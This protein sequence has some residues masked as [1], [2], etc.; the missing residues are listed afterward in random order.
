MIRKIASLIP[1]FLFLAAF[2]AP[3]PVASA[4]SADVKISLVASPD[5]RGAKGAAKYRNRG[6]EQEFQVEAE[7]SRRLAGAVFTV[8]VNDVAVGQMTINAF[9]KGRLSLNS[10]LG[11]AVP[12]ITPGTLVGV[13]T[14]DKAIVL[15][16][17][18]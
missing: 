13:T 18:F 11:D 6:G 4:N 17:K 1:L 2:V 16:G 12:V 5:F 8:W 14:A 3:T 9:G 10:N 15:A 7:V